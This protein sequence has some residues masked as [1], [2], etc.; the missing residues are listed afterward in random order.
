MATALMMA[1]ASI[2]ETSVGFYERT[3]WKAIIFLLAAVRK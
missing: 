1:A 2:S 3:S